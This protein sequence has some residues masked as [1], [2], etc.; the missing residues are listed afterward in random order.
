[1]ATSISNSPE[2]TAAIGEA[3][4]VT[5]RK[6]TVIVLSGTLGAGKTQWVKGFA[7][8]LGILEGIHSPTFS[9]IN[10]YE[11]GRLTLFHLDLYR[12]E[13][14]EEILRAGL[15]EYFDPPGVTVVE[16]GDKW[17]AHASQ[18]DLV[19]PTTRA[20]EWVTIESISEHTRRIIHE[21]P[22]H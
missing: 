5:S 17:F 12:L 1:M 4:A 9:L 10:I 16:W 2:E 18:Q 22:G 21:R 15:T 3:A 11:G 19:N 13:T 7:R 14:R 8:G 6:G 20:V